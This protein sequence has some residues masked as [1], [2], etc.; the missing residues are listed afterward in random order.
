[1][2]NY[3]RMAGRDEEF[4]DDLGAHAACIFGGAIV[5]NTMPKPLKAITGPLVG[6]TCSYMLR[7]V[8]RKCLPVVKDRL[9]KT[10]KWKV[11]PTYDFT[12]PVSPTAHTTPNIPAQTLTP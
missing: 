7:K 5:I 2:T 3:V 8:L 11:D 9:E 4:L 1:M 12:P 6:L 10:A